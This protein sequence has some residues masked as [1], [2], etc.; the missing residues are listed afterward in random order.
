M[1]DVRWRN[2][3]ADPIG[4]PLN[5]TFHSQLFETRLK[6]GLLTRHVD[7]SSVL[8]LPSPL[9]PLSVCVC[10]CRRSFACMHRR[11]FNIVC[12]LVVVSRLS[13]VKLGNQI[14]TAQ[15]ARSLRF[16]SLSPFLSLSL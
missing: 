6:I 9:S 3:D 15:Q 12:S 5:S 2:N 4:G 10:V 13:V 16:L 1:Y 7:I 14:I 8:L 11:L